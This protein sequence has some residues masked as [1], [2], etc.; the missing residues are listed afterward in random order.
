MPQWVDRCVESIKPKLRKS[1]PNESEKE[2][3]SRAFA[4]CQ[5]QYKK[6]KKKSES[7]DMDVF[8]WKSKM[9]V[10]PTLREAMVGVGDSD[11]EVFGL[12]DV[13]EALDEESRILTESRSFVE[14]MTGQENVTAE[15]EES[16][17]TTDSLPHIYVRGTAISEGTTRNLNTYPSEELRIAAPTLAG[18]PFQVDHITS[19]AQNIGKVLA[20]SYDPRSKSIS[21]VGRIRKSLDIAEAVR[22]GD[23]DTVSIGATAKDVLCSICGDSKLDGSCKHIVGREYEGE[24]AT[25]TPKQLK[26]V[27]LSVTPIPGDPNASTGVVTSHDSMDM[28]LTVFTESWKKQLGAIESM[29]EP[30]APDLKFQEE[31][32]AMKQELKSK[33]DELAKAQ[34]SVKAMLARKIAEAEIEIGSRKE[35]DLEDR[36]AELKNK[37]SN[38]LELLSETLGDQVLVARRSVPAESRGIVT[39]DV[40]SEVPSG[41]GREELKDLIREGMFRWDKPSPTAVKEVREWSRNPL[42]PLFAEYQERFR[43]HLKGESR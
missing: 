28:A 41:I 2:I 29:S 11:L 39:D 12:Q 5:D 34:D 38:A 9:K 23:I 40:P 18:C 20:S 36:V 1:Y 32:D 13:I 14:S 26:F 7:M 30:E 37:D 31:I 17:P 43:S 21:Y 16:E 3:T 4:I 15:F 19:S 25:R 27:E 10:F 22:L 33:D 8:R 42:N 35:S 6:K 24:I